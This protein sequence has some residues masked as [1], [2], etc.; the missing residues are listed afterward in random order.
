MFVFLIGLLN[1]KLWFYLLKDFKNRKDQ[2]LRLYGI[3]LVVGLYGGGK[4]M[5]M[6]KYL[7]DMRQK[8]GKRI[9]IATNYFLKGEDFHIDN[10]KDLRDLA[11][12]AMEKNIPLL[13]GYDEVQNEFTSRS[14]RDFPPQLQ[15]LLTQNRKGA[16]VQIIATAQRFDRVDKIWRELAHS[17]ITVKTF[18]GRLTIAR[19]YEYDDY[20]HINSSTSTNIKRKITSIKSECFVQTD[21]LRDSYNSY[22]FLKSALEK[23]YEYDKPIYVE[24]LI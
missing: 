8:Y 12:E 19:H 11:K 9:W 18:F 4:T 5:Y 17:I 23:E 6:S 1:P 16:G 15:M 2:P 13:V 20:I 21:E 22:Q 24:N 10:W 14:Y 3:K 7:L